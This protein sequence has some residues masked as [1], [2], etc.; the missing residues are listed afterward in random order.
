MKKKIF[1]VLGAMSG[2]SMD[3]VDLSLIKSDGDREFTC[4]SNNY[5]E[6]DPDLQ[7]EL[8]SIRKKLNNHID[9]DKYSD[10]L[11]EIEREYTLF[12]IKIIDQFLKKNKNHVDLIGFHGQTIF[13]DPDRKI[14]KQLGDG[15]LISQITKKIVINDFRQNDLINGGQGAPLSPIFHRLISIELNKKYNFDFPI[16]IINIGGITNITQI[17]NN[18]NSIESCLSALDIGPGN[19]LI[20]EWIRNNSKKKIDEQGLIA[21]NGMVNTLILNQAIDNFNIT[22]FKKSLDIKDFDIFFVKG[23]S[24]EDGCATITKFTAN[25]IANG[26]EYFNKINN[27]EP[28]HNLVCGG[29]RKNKF[30]IDSINKLFSYNGKKLIDIDEF[31]FD[32]DFIESQAFGYLAIRSY[33]ELPISFPGTTHCKSPT[34][35]GV[36]NKNF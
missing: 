16:N 1:T 21:K 11:M 35:G 13:H 32:G 4:I 33:L 20:D 28:K 29:G 8:I 31:N 24:L 19:C 36:L 30:L 25:L 15:K 6:F 7:K 26:I 3:G 22:S 2:T 14:T 27:L 34:I 9:L 17:K 23:L 18:S 12:N 5:V 10:E